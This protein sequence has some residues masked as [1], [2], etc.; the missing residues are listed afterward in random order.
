MGEA[1]SVFWNSSQYTKEE[2]PAHRKLVYAFCDMNRKGAPKKGHRLE[3]VKSVDQPGKP[4]KGGDLLAQLLRRVSLPMGKEG[5][6][7][8][9]K[10]LEEWRSV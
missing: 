1:E 9:G 10:E 2:K 8:S 3:K 4:G 6:S 7:D 5:V